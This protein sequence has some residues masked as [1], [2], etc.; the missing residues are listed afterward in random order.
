M[1]KNMI[2]LVGTPCAGKS[3]ATKEMAKSGITLSISRDEVRDVL[4]GKG[5]LPTRQKEEAVTAVYDKLVEQALDYPR[6]ENIIL[7]N[8]HCKEK[9]INEIIHRYH[10]RCNLFIMRFPISLWYAHLRNILR[11]IKSGK[12]IPWRVMKAMYDNYNKLDW[13]KYEH[14]VYKRHA[15]PPQQHR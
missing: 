8:T 9:Y 5:Y 2:I 13:T 11:R 14:M 6:L 7:D 15:F 3:S 4:F 12:W 1:K 10:H